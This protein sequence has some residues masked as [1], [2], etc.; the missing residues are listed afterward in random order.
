MSERKVINCVFCGDEHAPVRESDC[1]NSM[2]D[3]IASRVMT[4]AA[5][6]ALLRDL[7]DK[8]P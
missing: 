2:G 5:M 6:R 4:N 8:K 7:G 3:D 1:P